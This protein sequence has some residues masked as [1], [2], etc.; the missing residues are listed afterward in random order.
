MTKPDVTNTKLSKVVEKKVNVLPI[1]G[2]WIFQFDLDTLE[3][4]YYRAIDFEDELVNVF[5]KTPEGN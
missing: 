4:L 5:V 2:G 1:A 3:E